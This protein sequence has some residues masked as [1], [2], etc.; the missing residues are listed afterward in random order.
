M[1]GFDEKELINRSINCIIPP[2]IAVKHDSLIKKYIEEG[3][4]TLIKRQNKILYSLNSQGFLIP[5]QI[6]LKVEVINSD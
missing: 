6:H 5:T 3:N 2:F 1:F 4:E